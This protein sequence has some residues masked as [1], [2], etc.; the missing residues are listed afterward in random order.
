MLLYQHLQHGDPHKGVQEKRGSLGPCKPQIGSESMVRN[1]QKDV[2]R[3]EFHK[4][5]QIMHINFDSCPSSTM[6]YSPLWALISGARSPSRK[7]MRLWWGLRASCF[8]SPMPARTKMY[9]K[10]W[11][12]H[13]ISSVYQSTYIGIYNPIQISVCPQLF[14]P[15][16][17]QVW[18]WGRFPKRGE[19]PMPESL[20]QISA[21]STGFFARECSRLWWGALCPNI[22]TLN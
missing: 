11:T 19:E 13:H 16:L 17:S 21:E 15:D 7:T 12:Y 18:S 22:Y 6:K 3:F 20:N 10:N 4:I 2:A 1:P 8:P 9:F 5:S 14:N